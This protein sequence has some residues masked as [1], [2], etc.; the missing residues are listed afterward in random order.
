MSTDRIVPLFVIYQNIFD[1]FLFLFFE[2]DCFSVLF[3]SIVMKYTYSRLA[4][5]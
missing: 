3:Q 2:L 1:S 4:G 5:W